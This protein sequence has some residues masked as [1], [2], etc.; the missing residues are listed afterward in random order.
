MLSAQ[1]FYSYV[2]LLLGALNLSMKNIQEQEEVVGFLMFFTVLRYITLNHFTLQQLSA[3]QVHFLKVRHLLRSLLSCVCSSSDV[4]AAGMGGTKPSP[5][6]SSGWR[7]L[8]RGINAP[9]VIL[10]FTI[11]VC[12]SVMFFTFRGVYAASSAVFLELQSETVNTQMSTIQSI[13]H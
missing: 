10:C 7:L 8:C 2:S 6:G 3:E 9:P 13:I 4:D 1:N 12:Y 5:L 11:L